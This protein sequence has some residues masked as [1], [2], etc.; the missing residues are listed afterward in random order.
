MSTI[1]ISAP[2]GSINSVDLSV[3]TSTSLS[4]YLKENRGLAVSIPFGG[5]GK[6]L[7]SMGRYNS[8]GGTEDSVW[9]LRNGTGDDITGNL[10]GYGGGFSNQYD[11]PA[12]SDTFVVSTEFRTHL[13]KYQGRQKVKAA[14]TQEFNYDLTPGNSYLL[15]GSENSDILT[16]SSTYD[17]LTDTEYDPLKDTEDTFV[18]R[19]GNDILNLGGDMAA[20]TVSYMLNDGH[21]TINGFVKDGVYQD[22]L[23]FENIPSIDVVINGSDTEL[24]LGGGLSFG[25]GTHLATI[26]GVELTATDLGVNGDNLAPSNTAE[27]SFS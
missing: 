4:E 13:L 17:P 16:G 7:T 23:S 9:R 1:T 26:T 19:G 18:G 12:N 27:F 25:T 6:N 21:D 8:D 24:R 10:S 15:R 22:L 11:L 2:T 14:G 5:G 3:P 20:D